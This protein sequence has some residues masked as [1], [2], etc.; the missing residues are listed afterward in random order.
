MVRQFTYE[1][2]KELLK[3]VCEG[4][5]EELRSRGYEETNARIPPN[6]N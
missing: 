4:V 6:H 5:I 3:A 1:E 2:K